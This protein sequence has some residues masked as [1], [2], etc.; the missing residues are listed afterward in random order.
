MTP[1]ADWQ[2]ITHLFDELVEVTDGHRER[3]L[4]AVAETN[5]RVATEVRTLLHAHRKAD[6]RFDVPVV[7]RFS[8]EQLEAISPP[9]AL[10]RAG[11]VGAF[12]IVRKIW[13]RRN[14]RRLRSN[15]RRCDL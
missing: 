5:A 9:D 12:N 4:L 10:L 3:A 7:S 2:Q 6:G 15:A 11:R 8:S 13:R 1:D 14:G